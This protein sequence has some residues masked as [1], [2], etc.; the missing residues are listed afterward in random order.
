MLNSTITIKMK[1]RLNKLDSNDY[2]NIE[3]WQIVEAFNKAQVEWVRR[4]LHGGNQ[5]KEGDEGS[6]IRKDDLQVLLK[7]YE[8]KLTDKKNF[9]ISNVPQNYLQWKRID[10]E[11]NKDC[12]TNR[13]MIVYFAE[14]GDLSMLLRDAAKKPSFEWGETFATLMNNKIKIYNN[15]DFEISKG[16]FTYYK[17]PEKIQILNCVDPYTS[18]ASATEVL[19]EFKD[20]IVELLID[21]A[22]SILAGDMESNNQFARGS[23][24]AEKNN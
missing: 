7:E 22:V 18:L 10:I 4:Q 24:N 13:K 19:C 6:T 16:F 3:C 14:E 5:Y 9:Y 23:A 12:C 21:E 15:E 17:Q 1:Q 8:L 20:D 11:A 2:D